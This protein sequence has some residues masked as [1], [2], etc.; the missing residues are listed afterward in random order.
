M[1]RRG[2]STDRGA[3]PAFFLYGEPL[4][5]PD[6]RTVHVETIAARSSLHDWKIRAHRR[7]DLHQILIAWRGPI[8]PHL[9]GRKWVLRGPGLDPL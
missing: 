6:A 7:R 4:R 3:V 2:S 1:N 9:D 8:E 5:A